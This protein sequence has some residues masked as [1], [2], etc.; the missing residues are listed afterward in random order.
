MVDACA[1][2]APTNNRMGI[3]VAA[4]AALSFFIMRQENG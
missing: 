1:G 4:T 2:P 3:A